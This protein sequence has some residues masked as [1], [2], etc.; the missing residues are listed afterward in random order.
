MRRLTPLVLAVFFGAG[1][2]S[3]YPVRNR[4]TPANVTLPMAMGNYQRVY[5]T[6]YHIVNRYAVIKNASYR[7]GTIEGEIGEDNQ[8]FDRT[9]KTILCRIF[10]AEGRYDV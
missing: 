2:A 5:N 1:C 9:R 7:S 4:E 6:T 8:L 10:D 3:S